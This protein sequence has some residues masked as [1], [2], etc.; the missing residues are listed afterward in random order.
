MTVWTRLRQ[1]FRPP[2]VAPV[3]AD[4]DIGLVLMLY[5]RMKALE[6]E[7]DDL[8]RCVGLLTDNVLDC[9]TVRQ[10]VA[11]EIVENDEGTADMGRCCQ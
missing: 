6:R 2:V 8:R 11:Q 9:S 7:R 10:R 4:D 1:W 5:Q 3:V